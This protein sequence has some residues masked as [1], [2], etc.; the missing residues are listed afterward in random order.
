MDHQF[1]SNAL[2]IASDLREDQFELYALHNMQYKNHDVFVKFFLLLSGDI[3]LN[4]GPVKNPCMIC[5]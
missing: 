4:P 1:N 5:T 2:K 3:E